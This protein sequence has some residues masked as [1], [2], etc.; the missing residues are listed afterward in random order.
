MEVF[1]ES[2]DKKLGFSEIKI[3]ERQFSFI[4]AQHGLD[5]FVVEVVVGTVHQIRIVCVNYNGHN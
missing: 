1:G 2:A 4:V 5:I 3:E